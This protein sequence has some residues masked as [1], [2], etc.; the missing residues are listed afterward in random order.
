MVKTEYEHERK[1]WNAKAHK[2]EA[3]SFDEQINRA[4]R[5]KE[6]NKHLTSEIKTVLDIGGAT[7]VFS[8]PL[9]EKGIEVVHFDISEEMISIA[10]GKLK[11]K[12]VRNI[13]FEQGNSTDLSRY[14]NNSFDLVINMDGPISFCG[15][16]AEKAIKETIRVAKKKVIMTVSNK[17]N[18]I[19]S[20]LK[21]G[22]R[23][24]DKGFVPAIYEMFEKGYWHTFQFEENKEMG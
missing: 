10:K 15:I 7:G 6:I 18:M 16:D 19:V 14:K 20:I 5:W 17:A 24:S 12:E 9:A 2:E 1:W 21:S 13:T 23:F 8:I 11:G 3:D 4:L 22:I